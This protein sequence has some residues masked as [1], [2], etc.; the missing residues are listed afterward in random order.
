M[1]NNK[2]FTLVELL[3]VIVILAVILVIA[4]PNVIKI[5]NNAKLDSNNRQMEL[6]KNAVSKYLVQYSDEVT[7]PYNTT[8]SLGKLI[9]KNLIN[10]TIKNPIT[11]Q[12]YDDIRITVSKTINGIS[13]ETLVGP[14]LVAGMIPVYY[15]GTTYEWKK[16]DQTNDG[17]Q[18]YDYAQQKWANV[19]TVTSTNRLAYQSASVG[20]PIAM[21]DINT[22]FVWIPRYKY[23]IPVGSGSREIDIVFEQKDI[24]KSN[25]DAINSYYTHPSF[26]FGDKELNGIWVAKFETTGS[27]TNG[28]TAALTIKPDLPST[29]A[30]TVKTFYDSVKN[31]MQ[32]DTANYGFTNDSDVHMMKNTDWGAAAYLSNSEYGK[33][34][35][36]SYIGNNK[37]LYLN[38]SSSYYTGRSMGTYNANGILTPTYEYTVNGYYTYDGKCAFIYPTLP[39]PCATGSTGQILPDKTLSYGAS[40]TG[41][42]YGIYDMSG[43]SRDYVMGVYKPD[44]IGA[45]KDC[46][47]FS[48]IYAPPNIC[49]T[50]IPYEA[51]Y[52]LLNMNS[53]YYDSYKIGSLSTGYIKGDATYEVQGWYADSIA[54]VTYLNPWS[55]RGSHSSTSG[56]GIY[57]MTSYPGAQVASYGF[58]IVLTKN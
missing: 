27:I 21:S 1:K 54:A 18:W 8:V 39:D 12:P 22:M 40:T 44:I 45:I 16:A 30:Q 14:D 31:T 11:N 5:I 35:N 24:P 19:V 2:G 48:S 7:D 56:S 28:T 43:G 29:R 36:S 10:S 25:G 41:N 42:I 20:T 9:E 32:S 37:E 51:T 52:D 46:S 53:K 49:P 15:D 6:I 4:I 55:L 58:R 50:T 13:Y 3:A 38:N 17:N 33:Y 23:L 47:G 57:N 26:T 34:G